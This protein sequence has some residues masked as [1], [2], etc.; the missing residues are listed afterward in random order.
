MPLTSRHKENFLEITVSD[1]GVGIDPEELPKIF[2]KFYRVKHPKTRQVI[3]TGLGLAIVKGVI[4]SHRGT[5][6]RRE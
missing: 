2:D 6:A 4:D 5:V 3:G 1:N